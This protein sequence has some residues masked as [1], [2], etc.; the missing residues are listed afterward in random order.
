MDWE[1]A[2]AREGSPHQPKIAVLG[3]GNEYRGD[4]GV[5]PYIIRRLKLRGLPAHVELKTGEA[6]SLI[7]YWNGAHTAIVVDAV[8]AN[9]EPGKIHRF[10]AHER[11]LPRRLFDAS[12]H[13]FG[14]AKSVELARAL[15]RLPPRLIVYGI[16]GKNFDMGS[17]LSPEVRQAALTVVELVVRGILRAQ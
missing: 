2:P 7:D 1:N 15:D 6:A 16:E 13:A 14:L 12:T 4:D 3:I 9:S 11:P 5:G 10:D 17:G 8:A